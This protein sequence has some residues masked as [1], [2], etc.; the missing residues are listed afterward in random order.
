MRGQSGT[1]HFPAN[2]PV[3]ELLHR[4][5]FTHWRETARLQSRVEILESEAAK[6]GLVEESTA[7]E[8]SAQIVN[9]LLRKE[10][11]RQRGQNFKSRDQRGFEIQDFNVNKELARINPELLKFFLD[12]SVNDAAVDAKRRS[13]NLTPGG[14]DQD[15]AVEENYDAKRQKLW[16]VYAISVLIFAI[17]PEAKHPFHL[18]LA[19]VVEALGGCLALLRLL[20]QLG[21]CAAKDTLNRYTENVGTT[22]MDKGPFAQLPPGC[23]ASFITCRINNADKTATTALRRFGNLVADMHVVTVQLHC[24]PSIK[25]PVAAV[26]ETGVVGEGEGEPGP[27]H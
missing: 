9:G 5:W 13:N 7:L 26:P 12:L 24:K 1:L 14:S 22:I 2:A 10:V 19:D 11:R 8:R 18:M 6:S 25:L 17:N 20:N 16:V 21:V 4:I 15:V 3:V 23:E 27:Y